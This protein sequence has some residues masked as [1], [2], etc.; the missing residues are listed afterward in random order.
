MEILLIVKYLFLFVWGGFC[1]FIACHSPI[2]NWL[3]GLTIL[4]LTI[5][6]VVGVFHMLGLA[7]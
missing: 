7:G 1:A 2:E 5:T 4:T 3:Q 6:S